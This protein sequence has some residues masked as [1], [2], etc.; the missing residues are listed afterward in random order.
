MLDIKSHIR[1]RESGISA[2]KRMQSKAYDSQ[3]K[4]QCVQLYKAWIWRE[5]KALEICGSNTIQEL[6]ELTLPKKGEN[7]TIVFKFKI[8]AVPPGF[9]DSL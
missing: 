3:Q 8:P 7:I 2:T 1:Y 6:S 4:Y 9:H 5:L